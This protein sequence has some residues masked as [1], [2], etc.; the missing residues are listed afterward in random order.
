M[1]RELIIE[2]DGGSRGNPGPSG[3]GA[4]VKDAKTG[5][6]LKEIFEF[7]GVA[8][9]NVAE[10]S[11]LV[12]GLTAAN[13]IDPEAQIHV[14]MDSKLVIEQMSGRWQIKHPDMRILAAQ[15][16]KVHA[17]NLVDYTWIPREENSAADHLANRA[18]DGAVTPNAD[19][20]QQV[21]FMTE[22]LTSGEAATT[23]YFVRHGETVL[24]NSRAFSGANGTNPS[25][26]EI[27]FG[28][29]ENVAREMA[30]IKPD[31][32][33]A[34]PM[35]RTKQTA[36]AISEATGLSIE[37]DSTWLECAFGDWDGFTFQEI[38]AKFP[39]EAQ[40]WLNSS[41]YEPPN[42]ESFDEVGE[43]VDAAIDYVAAKYVGKKVCIVTHNVVI[44]EI[45][46]I[47]LMAPGAA[48]FH[49]DASPCSITTLSVW[50]SDGLRVLRTFSEVGHHR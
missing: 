32:L 15:A 44:R 1:A 28:Q 7:I 21:N 26:N 27:G 16:R 4:V 9:N 45:A 34:S 25:L 10:Y 13:E 12:A 6:V 18:M 36:E 49:I 11:G 14:R 24:T 2:A 17:P 50:P 47:T 30:K 41:G 37:E 8:T 43:R 19:P 23:F 29:A 33:I 40:L 3:F 39:V 5:A 22:R 31:I 48:V 20:S 38:K 35:L 46:R 42:G